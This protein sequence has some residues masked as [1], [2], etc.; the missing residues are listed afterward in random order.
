MIQLYDNICATCRLKICSN[1]FPA[2]NDVVNPNITMSALRL[3]AFLL[4]SCSVVC[5]LYEAEVITGTI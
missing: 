2:K 5:T 3:M 1:I 4:G